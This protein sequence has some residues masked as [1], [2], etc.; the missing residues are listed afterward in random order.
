MDF[1]CISAT[2]CLLSSMF[3]WQ[4]LREAFDLFDADG[5]GDIDEKEL[6]SILIM[7]L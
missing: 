6:K 4:E 7:T 1:P 3:V 2:K 5:S